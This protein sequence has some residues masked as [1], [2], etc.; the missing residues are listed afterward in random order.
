MGR[1]GSQMLWT[2]GGSYRKQPFG[3]EADLEE[4]IKE[5]SGELFGPNRI[6]LDVKKKIGTKSKSNIPDGYLID[7]SSSKEPILRVVENELASH[8]P[9]RHVA[10]QIIEFSL[11]FEHAPYKVKSVVK[12]ALLADAGAMKKCESYA[13]ANNFENVDV[14]LDQMVHEGAF[15]ALVVIDDLQDKLDSVLSRKFKFGVEVLTLSKF[16]NPSGDY[17]YAFEPFLSDVVRGD[18]KSGADGH[19]DVSDLD[20]VVVPAQDEGFEQVFLGEDRWYMVRIH[21]SMIPRLKHVAAYRVAPTSAITHVAPISTIEPW[22]ETDKKV[23]NFAEPAEKI[24]PLKLVSKGKVKAPQSL[25]YT[26]YDRLMA[27]K[28]LDEAF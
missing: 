19:V 26:S 9:L 23:I 18:P 16:V 22:Q 15:A 7:L 27:A 2:T 21:G 13:M 24:K 6:Y 10:V 25:R 3:K 5:V 20:T 8:D 14:L 12:N 11:A 4:A 28:T 17:I 1:S